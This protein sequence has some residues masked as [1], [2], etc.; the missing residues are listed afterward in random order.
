MSP[1]ALLS[2]LIRTDSFA[3]LW[4]WIV[5]GGIWVLIGQRV[6]GVPLAEV[7]AARRGRDPGRLQNWLRLTLPAIAGKGEPLLLWALAGFGLSTSA[8]TGFGYGLEAGQVVF[9]LGAPLLAV[10]L[11]RR[12]LARRLLTAPLPPD[13]VELARR[14]LRHRWQVQ[15]IGALSLMVTAFW[16]MGQVML[17]SYG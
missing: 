14:L 16:G 4:F 11:L 9:L 6:L 7:E 15:A 1:F 3:S 10:A 2:D 13:S 12:G 5:A 8:I 17:A